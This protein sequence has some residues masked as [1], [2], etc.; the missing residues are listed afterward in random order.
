MIADMEANKTSSSIVSE[1]FL[2]L[3]NNEIV[4]I[5]QSYLHVP[6]TIRLNMTHFFSMKVPNKIELQQIAL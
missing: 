4:F 6:R 2:I 3:F 5:S 1:L